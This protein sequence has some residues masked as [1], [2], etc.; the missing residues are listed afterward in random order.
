MRREGIWM[1]RNPEYG[2]GRFETEGFSMNFSYVRDTPAELAE[3]FIKY[4]DTGCSCAL[5]DGEG[6]DFTFVLSDCDAFIMVRDAHG[7]GRL[8]LLETPPVCL[9]CGFVRDIDGNSAVWAEKFHM[10]D[11]GEAETIRR[12][13]DGMVEKL[14]GHI[15]GMRFHKCKECPYSFGNGDGCI[16]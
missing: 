12:R 14:K 2:W 9:A 1:I 6:E 16:P 3:C 13:L 10:A 4:F 5:C 7:D 11:G 8:L 15:R